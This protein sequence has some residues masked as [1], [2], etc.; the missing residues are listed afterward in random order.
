MKRSA[1]ENKN[2]KNVRMKTHGQTEKTVKNICGI[3]GTT[4]SVEISALPEGWST[5]PWYTNLTIN[6]K[7]SMSC[8]IKPPPLCTTTI[9]DGVLH[10]P[11]FVGL[12][13]FGTP[14]RDSRSLGEAMRL[15]LEFTGS[16]RKTPPQIDATRDVLR[17]LQEVGGAM[18]VLP[19][20]FGKTVCSLWLSHQLGRRTLVI[21]HSEALADQWIDRIGLFLPSAS[22]GRIQ[23]D[24]VNIE[25]DFVVAM[26]QSLLKR[27]YGDIFTSFG[28]VIIDESHHI[29]A[30]TFSRVLPK[31]PSRYILGLSATP[32]RPDGCGAALEWLLGKIAYRAQRSTEAVTVNQLT[33]TRGAEKELKNR[34][35]NPLASRMLSMI[36]SDVVR[37]R[38]LTSLMIT[39]AHEGRKIIVLSD[40]LDQLLFFERRLRET[41]DSI[42]VGRVVGGMKAAQRDEGF[43]ATIILSTYQFASEGI[44]IPRLDTLIMASPRGNIEQSLGRILREHT[45][46][47]TPLVIDVKDPFSLFEPMSWKRFAYYKKQK[48]CVCSRLDEEEGD[49]E[50]F[51]VESDD[52]EQSGSIADFAFSS[53]L[54]V[55]KDAPTFF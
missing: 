41:D 21:V 6:Q 23:Q 10:L 25:C 17:Q 16:L 28:T 48:Y 40:R 43:E 24:T 34:A 14:T 13:I 38:W 22:I 30:P 37:N 11:R 9:L 52:V 35:G 55:T 12:D 15:Q 33:Y 31:L 50:P 27:D 3:L 46:K 36:A 49:K 42:T 51:F 32:D 18:L 39:C 1:V 26:I 20:G 5:E 7:V 44:D 2:L 19:C 45:D 8:P 29:A 4:Y 53:S 47:K 54:G